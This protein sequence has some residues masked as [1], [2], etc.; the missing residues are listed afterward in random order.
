MKE[1]YGKIHDVSFAQYEG[2]DCRVFWID[3]RTTKGLKSYLV[4]VPDEDVLGWELYE[5]LTY[6]V[7]GEENQDGDIIATFA[8]T[9]S[10]W[11]KHCGVHHS[12]GYYNED[13]G[14][15]ACSEVCLLALYDG[16]E[17][18]MREDMD[19]EVV[20]WMDVRDTEYA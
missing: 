12:E 5:G 15:Y 2:R 8:D 9:H 16:D 7:R 4:I 14:E 1:I 20:C 6:L 17:D 18:R 19:N 10:M 11:C 13:T 3:E